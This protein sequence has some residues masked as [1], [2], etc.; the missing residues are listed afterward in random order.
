MPV[1]PALKKGAK[2]IWSL[3]SSLVYHSTTCLKLNP[4]VHN[5]YEEIYPSQEW[6]LEMCVE[7]KVDS[8]WKYVLR[9]SKPYETEWEHIISNNEKTAHKAL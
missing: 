9:G 6:L 7:H 5:S 3:M 4:W 2:T 1:I 8:A